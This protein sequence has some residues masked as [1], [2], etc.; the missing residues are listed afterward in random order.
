MLLQTKNFTSFKGFLLHG[1]TG[2]SLL[3]LYYDVLGY[4][5][6]YIYDLSR[7]VRVDF[8]SENVKEWKHVA[9]A[10]S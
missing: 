8:C 3:K 9:R 1:V 2:N 7:S 10:V 5:H 6:S 4:T